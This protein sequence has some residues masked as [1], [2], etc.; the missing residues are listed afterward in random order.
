MTTEGSVTDDIRRLPSRDPDAARRLWEAYF[1][2]LVNQAQAYLRTLRVCD[3][4]ED[5]A[6][7]AFKSIILWPRKGGSRTSTA[8]TTFGGSCST[9]PGRRPS[10]ARA[11]KVA[12][13]RS[14]SRT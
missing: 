2:R 10:T 11:C 4:G 5:V 8:A 14:I 3:D 12:I 9:R 6:L 1:Q 7:S 13:R